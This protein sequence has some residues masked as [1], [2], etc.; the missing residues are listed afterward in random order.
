VIGEFGVPGNDPRWLTMLDQAMDYM[1]SRNMSGTYWAAG[2]WWGSYPLS[3]EPTNI[4]NNPV[5]KPQM[6]ILSKYNNDNYLQ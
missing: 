1:K 4:D 5:D 3:V 6:A 2:P